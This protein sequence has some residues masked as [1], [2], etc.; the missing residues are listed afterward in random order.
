MTSCKDFALPPLTQPEA[1]EEAKKRKKALLRKQAPLPHALGNPALSN[2]WARGGDDPLNVDDLK[3]FQ[4][5]V[6]IL[7]SF[8]RLTKSC[9]DRKA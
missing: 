5:C 1:S 2:V 6:R 4:L 3:N 9:V 7:F 8:A